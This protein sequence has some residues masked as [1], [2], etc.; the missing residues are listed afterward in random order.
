MSYVALVINFLLKRSR[1]TSIIYCPPKSFVWRIIIVAPYHCNAFLSLFLFYNQARHSLLGSGVSIS[2][3]CMN[4]CRYFVLYKV[5]FVST[6]RNLRH[7]YKYINR[8][9]ASQTFTRNQT[10]ISCQAQ[11][12]KVQIGRCRE[13]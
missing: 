7:E 4:L 3:V 5:A 9:I 10:I 1:Y 2:W 8:C 11:V 12:V 6:K 13:S